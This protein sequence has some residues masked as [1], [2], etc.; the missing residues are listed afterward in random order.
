[1]SG[2]RLETSIFVKVMSL[3]SCDLKDI[4]EAYKLYGRTT[5]TTKTGM[6]HESDKSILGLI[7]IVTLP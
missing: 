5:K 3:S 4:E 1:M 2:E 7:L 6:N